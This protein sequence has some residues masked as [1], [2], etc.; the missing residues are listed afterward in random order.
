[1]RFIPC[2]LSPSEVLIKC[3]CQHL[4]LVDD[5]VV[6]SEPVS[7]RRAERMEQLR[8]DPTILFL[9]LMRLTARPERLDIMLHETALIC[10]QILVSKYS[11]AFFQAVQLLEHNKVCLNS[12]D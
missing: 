9:D 7:R 3:L 5:R 11:I 10:L 12:I 6:H 8:L 1:M 4:V 2:G